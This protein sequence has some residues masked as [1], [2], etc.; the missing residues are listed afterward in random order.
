MT[1]EPDDYAIERW[2]GPWLRHRARLSPDVIALET[3][4]EKIS[5][6]ALD[7]RANDLADQL[8]ERGLRAGDGV[9]LLLSNDPD[10]AAFVHAAWYRGLVLVPLNTRLSSHELQFQL[11]SS[12]AVLLIHGDAELAQRIVGIS[13]ALPALTCVKASVLIRAAGEGKGESM[14]AHDDAVADSDRPLVILYTSGTSGR[15][16]GVVL[17]AANFLHSAA[18]AA[19]LL[20][21]AAQK[22]WL[23][24]MPLFHVGGLSILFRSVLAGATVVMQDRFDPE[25]VNDALDHESV[26][27]VSL[28]ANMLQRVLVARAGSPAPKELVFVLLGGGPAPRSL[29]D[30]A[31]AAGIAIAPTYGLTEAA[32][33][34]ATRPPDSRVEPWDAGLVPLPG[35]QIRIVGESGDSL[36]AGIA[37]EIEVR[38]P[39]VM[40]GYWR[41]GG[42]VSGASLDEGWLRTGDIGSIAPDGSLQVFD[43]R[44]DLIVSGGENVYPA[45]VEA[46]LLEHPDVA[47]A[48]VAGV[49]DARFGRRPVA[50]LV[51]RSG[52]AIDDDAVLAFCRERLAGYKLPVRIHWVNALPRTASG[53]LMRRDLREV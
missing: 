3:D 23:L 34:V 39:T 4:D 37:G 33:Q 44:Q 27:G 28:V 49:E 11:E 36:A 38:G 20:G 35:T 2:S 50:W 22:R 14:R 26:T 29:F 41:H 48:G 21:A 17:S 1:F 8:S 51:A 15:P 40:R 7:Q 19:E 16:K 52:V 31:R 12:G 30:A 10:F 45:E 24:C 6:A 42:E 32:S 46:A 5:Y 18:G 25:S 47:E 43:R 13:E 9:A 53:K